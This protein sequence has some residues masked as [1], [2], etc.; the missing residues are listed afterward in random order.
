MRSLKKVLFVS[1]VLLLSTM[2]FAEQPVIVQE[3]L[4]QI[5]FM[6]GRVTQLADAMPQSTY[7]WRP[8]DG[9][10]SVSEV[11]LHVAFG[12]YIYVTV[13]GGTVPEEVGFVM[14]FSKENN[15]DTQTT[16]KA[17]IMEKMNKSFD[18]LK[19][20]VAALTEEELNQ[21]VE[22]FGMKMSLR[23]L[24]ISMISHCHE[25]LGQSIAYARMNG[26]VPPWSKKDSEG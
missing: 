12:N 26:V 20:R 13:S 16:N 15:W 17:M 11:Y 21:E 10:R 23:N 3:F 4:G 14:D 1:V 22:A 18:I 2:S 8:M 19:E 6:R 5:D 25:H 24:I 7:E 9:V